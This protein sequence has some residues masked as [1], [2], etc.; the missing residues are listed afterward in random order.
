[1]SEGTRLS[2]HQRDSQ[3]RQGRDVREVGRV[4]SMAAMLPFQ[5]VRWSRSADW[6]R[7]RQTD[8]PAGGPDFDGE[9]VHRGDR[10]GVRLQKGRPRG[11]PFRCPCDAGG[12][13]NLRDGRTGDMA[14]QVGERADMRV[15]PRSGSPSRVL[16]LRAVSHGVTHPPEWKRC[17]KQLRLPLGLGY[18]A[19]WVPQ[20]SSA[21]FPANGCSYAVERVPSRNRCS[22]RGW[23]AACQG[24]RVRCPLP[25]RAGAMV[26][27]ARVP[28][29]LPASRARAA[30]KCA[31][32][33]SLLTDARIADGANATS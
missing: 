19:G 4:L 8:E 28:L 2:E 16:R 27:D 33:L 25:R 15:W 14:T 3:N 11:R 20:A 7:S 6:A 1:M 21:S 23:G 22:P 29:D 13:Q 18:G 5:P 30:R 10:A 9:E 24:T 17:V 31:N 12:L 32:A 26:P